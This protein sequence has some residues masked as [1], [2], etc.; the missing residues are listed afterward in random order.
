MSRTAYSGP[1]FEVDMPTTPGRGV[2]IL[3]PVFNDWE[4]LRLL[5]PAIDRAL[6]AAG[7][8]ARVFVVDDG[9][10][11]EPP[12]EFPEWDF[13]ALERVDLLSLRRNLGH[14]RAL[15]IGLSYIERRIG[16]EA[17]VVMDGDGEDA[18]QDV[19]RLL[20]RLEAE[21]GRKIV[22]AE[23]ARR[24]E[25]LAFRA[26]YWLYRHAH[27]L[28]TGQRVRV[29]NFS[30]IPRRRLSSLVCVTELWNHYAAAAIQSRQPICMIPTRRAHRLRGRSTMNFI[31]LVTHG[32]SAIS[33]Y[34]GVVGVRLLV[35]SV[36]LAM[37]AIGAVVAVVAVRLFTELAIPG[38]ATTAA[39]FSMILLTQALLLAGLFVFV[40]LGSRNSLTFLPRRDYKH[41]VYGVTRLYAPGRSRMVGPEAA[42]RDLGSTV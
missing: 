11:L 6:A 28:L 39:S 16:P 34:N 2:V 9:S 42:A 29:G 17:V 8:S 14:Q 27:Y 7:R 12:D 18:P 22:F 35:L 30:A 15:A 10:T 20:D 5:L 1:H 33:V 24:S 23:R 13:R 25:G 3:I 40:I 41:F 38:W 4:S 32:L 36:L 37:M 19:P 31:A 21:R 26:F